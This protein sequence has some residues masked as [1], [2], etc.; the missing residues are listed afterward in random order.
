[1]VAGE[2]SEWWINIS[3]SFHVWYDYAMFKNICYCW[4]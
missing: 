3:A 4:E 2:L 1:M